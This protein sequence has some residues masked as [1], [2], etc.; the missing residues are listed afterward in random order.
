MVRGKMHK[1][2]IREKDKKK[3]IDNIERRG[4]K[5]EEAKIEENVPSGFHCLCL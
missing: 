3:S 1:I 4:Q 5:D 2:I